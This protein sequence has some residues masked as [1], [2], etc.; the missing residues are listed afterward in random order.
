MKRALLLVLLLGGAL[1]AVAWQPPL[2]PRPGDASGGRALAARWAALPTPEREEAVVAEV[3][4]GNVPDFWRHFVDVPTGRAVLHVAPDYLAVGSDDDFLRMPLTPAAAQRLADRLECVLPTAKLVDLIYRAAPL[5]LAPEPMPPG[6]EMT[7]LAAFVRHE[8]LVAAARRAAFATHP[9]GTLTAGHKK[10]LVLTPRLA[11]APGRVAIYGWHRAEGAPIQPLFLGHAD[12]WVD[13]SHGVRLV[14]RAVE[15]DGAAR[16]IDELLAD[17]RWWTLLS[18]EG[19]CGPARWGQIRPVV[20]TMPGESNEALFLADGVRAVLNRPTERAAEQP[21]ELLLYAVP[22]GNTIEQTLGRRLRADDDWHFDIQHVAAQVRWLRAHG[23]ANLALAV[24]EP[25]RGSWPVWRREVKEAERKIADVVAALQRLVPGARLT[26]AGHS[27]GG[28]FVFGGLDAFERI[29]DEVERIAFLDSNYA[30]DAARGQAEKLA[31]WLAASPAHRLYVAAYEDF[32]ARLDG[33]TFV[34]ESGGTWGRSQAMQADLAARFPFTVTEE[35]PL[36]GARAA[37]GRVVF[38]LRRNP[39]QAV[40][41][42]RLVELNGL[43]QAMQAG[44]PEEGRGYRYLGPRAYED[45]IAR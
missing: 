42:T 11:A 39:E 18:G 29:P 15:W 26:L 27:A 40:W 13:Y 6:P 41:H 17:D 25:G 3:L 2:P 16:P 38:Q 1:H 5:K 43:I 12:T 31:V 24:L 30:Y 4:R 28:S 22:A 34:S 9:L 45:R 36:V 20:P 35:G 10:D 44:T 32:R 23:H 7:T 19:P 8:A 37:D 33:K 14:A 21:A